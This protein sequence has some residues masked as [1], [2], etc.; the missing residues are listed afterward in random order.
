L[1]QLGDFRISSG[2]PLNV[3]VSAQ[4]G[5]DDARWDLR[6]ELLQVTWEREISRVYP[7]LSLER[8]KLTREQIE[9]FTAEV[10]SQPLKLEEF[11][12]SY[13]DELA[14][15]EDRGSTS[16]DLTVFCDDLIAHFTHEQS[17]WLFRLEF[18]RH[19]WKI[20][21]AYRD[22]GLISA[23]PLF[24]ALEPTLPSIQNIGTIY[25]SYMESVNRES[26]CIPDILEEYGLSSSTSNVRFLNF[27]LY[28][29]FEFI[30]SPE[31]PLIYISISSLFERYEE[32]IRHFDFHECVEI[33]GLSTRSG[34]RPTDVKISV[35]PSRLLRAL[36]RAAS[37]MSGVELALKAW[38]RAGRREGSIQGIPASTYALIERAIREK[39]RVISVRDLKTM[40]G[41]TN[42]KVDPFDLEVGPIVAYAPGDRYLA[43][44]NVSFALRNWVA[45]A[46]HVKGRIHQERVLTPLIPLEAPRFDDRTLRSLQ[47]SE[48]CRIGGVIMR[49]DA[50]R[51][52][53]PA[54]PSQAS[55]WVKERAARSL[56]ALLR[57]KGYMRI[58]DVYFNKVVWDLR[59][60]RRATKTQIH[61]R[62]KAALSSDSPPAELV[63]A[64][65][66]KQRIAKEAFRV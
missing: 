24:V 10:V 33:Y 2:F 49:A 29:S 39:D 61:D 30:R 35:K 18:F 66:L 46:T 55:R 14:T 40:F 12:G 47:S 45:D 26:I 5:C 52:L 34:M 17:M 4:L 1:K 19:N 38:T 13:F 37:D 21:R 63:G 11:L 57:A 53:T 15:V 58:G 16:C 62:I 22:M 42:I 28:N 8:G 36:G 41:A 59:D 48:E 43:G 9:V 25:R 54:A 20:A 51:K 32:I 23:A 65:M 44:D 60:E 31:D 50:L 3:A 27:L 7:S 6:A 64:P 56:D